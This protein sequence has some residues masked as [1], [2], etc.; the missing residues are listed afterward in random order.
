MTQHNKNNK[1]VTH[2]DPLKADFRNF[3]FVLWSHLG[4][5]APTKVQ[6]DIAH[7][8]QHG[9]RRRIIEAFRGVGKSWI[10][11]VDV[12]WFLTAT[13]ERI[14]VVSASKDRADSFSV[15]VKRLD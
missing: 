13:L 3:L 12:L 5:G 15:F 4:L 1:V 9:G 7:F 11:A 10:T 14:L 2:T 6:Y 8:L